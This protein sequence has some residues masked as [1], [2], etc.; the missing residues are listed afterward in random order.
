M[1]L[2][3]TELILVKVEPPVKNEVSIISDVIHSKNNLALSKQLDVDFRE[4]LLNGLNMEVLNTLCEH[5]IDLAKELDDVFDLI[6]CEIPS[7]K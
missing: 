2:I 1:S 5:R 6:I 7:L 4:Y 3:F